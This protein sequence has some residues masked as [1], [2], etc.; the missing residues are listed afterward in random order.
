M[1]PA[2]YKQMASLF[3]SCFEDSPDKTLRAILESKGC[4][5]EEI[6]KAVQFI[7]QEIKPVA[8]KFAGEFVNKME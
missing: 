1:K 6:T 7:E 4:S 8:E 5:E 2:T 3:L